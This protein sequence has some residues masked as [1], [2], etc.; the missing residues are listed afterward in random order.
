METEMIVVV[1]IFTLSLIVSALSHNMLYMGVTTACIAT[2]QVSPL[3][4]GVTPIVIAIG[5]Y[6]YYRE[7]VINDHVIPSDI[8]EWLLLKF[9]GEMNRFP[10]S[11]LAPDNFKRVSALHYGNV[12]NDGERVVLKLVKE[13]GNISTLEFDILM[14]LEGKD[15]T[16]LRTSRVRHTMPNRTNTAKAP[17]DEM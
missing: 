12:K 6:I 9:L 1:T 15:Y 11:D 2:Y 16:H 5:Y 14:K 7:S 3:L 4:A 17:Q 13:S 8:P 10:K